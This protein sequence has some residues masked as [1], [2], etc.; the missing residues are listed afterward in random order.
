MMKVSVRT[1][2]GTVLGAT[3]LF[4]CAASQLHRKGVADIDRGNYE[5]GVA[6]LSA[7]VQ[8][9]PDNL[10]YKLDLAARRESSIQKLVATADGLRAAGQW[11]Q[12]VTTYRRV[13]VI[14]PTDQRAKRGI[15]GVEADRRHASMVAEAY[16]G[17]RAQGLRCGG[18]DSA[19]RA[20]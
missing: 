14:N 1:I 19:C 15:D 6:E 10:S 7:A 5:D 18:R 20:R 17:F 2:V 12:A 3:L 9:S 16:Q 4:G 8:S 11:D 13:L